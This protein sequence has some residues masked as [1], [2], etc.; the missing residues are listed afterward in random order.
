MTTILTTKTKTET[1]T[2]PPSTNNNNTNNNNQTSDTTIIE[3][4]DPIALLQ[5]H[6]HN[7]A[8]NFTLLLDP[9]YSNE[10]Y[11]EQK[12]TITTNTA[13]TPTTIDNSFQQA[14]TLINTLQLLK[15]SDQTKEIQLKQL[16][17]L[18]QQNEQAKNEMESTLKE[19]QEMLENVKR[20]RIQA[21]NQALDEFMKQTKQ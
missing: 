9:N 6:L 13:A 8:K 12:Q 11:L 21:A 4:N 1:T 5:N 7:I 20:I 10:E 14:E 16:L 18:A 2:P 17:D 3:E 19:A 15:H